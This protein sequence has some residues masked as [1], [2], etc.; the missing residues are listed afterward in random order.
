[1]IRIVKDLGGILV[2][3]GYI[4]DRSNGRAKFELMD[5]GK[6]VS[7][8]QMDVVTFKP[9]ECPLCK[10]GIPVEKPGSRGNK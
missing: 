5:G 1:M 7:V 3:V 9:E 6:Q 8:L 4:V 2:G 10:K